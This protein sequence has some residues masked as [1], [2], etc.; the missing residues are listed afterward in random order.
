V[1]SRLKDR[2]GETQI[3]IPNLFIRIIFVYQTAFQSTDQ[4]SLVRYL[5]KPF[6]Q[7]KSYFSIP[8][9]P[10]AK[11]STYNLK[12]KKNRCSAPSQ[13]GQAKIRASE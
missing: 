5:V 3:G 13:D 2:C 7:A 4:T 6:G 12:K 11:N 9:M 8:L 10:H 1:F